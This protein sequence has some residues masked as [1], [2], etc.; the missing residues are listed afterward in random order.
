MD[1]AKAKVNRSKHGVSFADAV[2]T[3]EDPLAL[4]I[5]DKGVLGKRD[6]LRSAPTISVV[7]L[8]LVSL[9]EVTRFG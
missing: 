4:T 2:G 8:Q 3:L 9:G 5:E 6:S 1:P 7:F